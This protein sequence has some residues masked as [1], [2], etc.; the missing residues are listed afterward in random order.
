[1]P[2]PP[3]VENTKFYQLSLD[4]PP[5]KLRPL[6]QQGKMW[7]NKAAHLTAGVETI[8]LNAMSTRERN[9]MTEQTWVITKAL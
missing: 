3:E 4:K 5:N 6:K 7:T 2:T 1:M 8:Q 9:T